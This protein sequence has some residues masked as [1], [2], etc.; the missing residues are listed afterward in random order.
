MIDLH[1]PQLPSMQCDDGCGE[2]CGVN[3][4]RREEFRRGHY[5]EGMVW[6]E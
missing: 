4:V 2:C 3:F 6:R 1:L 5:P